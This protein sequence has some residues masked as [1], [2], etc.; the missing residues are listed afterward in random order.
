MRRRTWLR[1][2][3]GAV[4]A[5]AA[6]TIGRADE[7][8]EVD[9][10]LVLAV[11]VSRSIDEDEARLQRQGY[12]EALADRRVIEAMTGGALKRIAI[13]YVE[14]AG[15]HYQRTLINWSLVDSAQ[16]AADFA[17]KLEASPF[18]S[19][20]WTAVGAG[21]AYAGEKFNEPLFR[22]NRKVIDISGDGKNNNGP[23]AEI[24]RDE[25]VKRGIVING[26]P[27][28]SER[29]NFGRPPEADLDVYY[30]EKVIGGQGSF[31]MPAKGFADF[32]RA[33]RSKMTREIS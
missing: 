20:S 27:I 22:S 15:S 29:T 28:L 26:L 14:W 9:L 10:R 21:L 17:A 16:A 24:V 3:G 23:P 5:A 33:I 6:P 19:Q 18:T 8:V 2:A 30:E 11:D 31:I 13:A 4:L 12:L 32:G 7:V 25:L 1:G